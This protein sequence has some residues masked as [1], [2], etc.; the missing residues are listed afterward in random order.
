MKRKDTPFKY[1][2]IVLSFDLHIILLQNSISPCT[3]FT[4]KDTID[5]QDQVNYMIYMNLDVNRNV[6]W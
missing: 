6:R 1:R 2:T 4:P 5:I 3:Y